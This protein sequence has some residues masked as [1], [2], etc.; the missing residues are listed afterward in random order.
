MIQGI[1]MT[2]QIK[3]QLAQAYQILGH[4]KM[5]DHTYTHLSARAHDQSSLYIYPFGLRFEEVRADALMRVSFDGTILDGHEYQYNK[6]GYLIHGS[7]YEARPDVQAVFHLHTPA[8]VAVSALEEGLMPINQWA[9]HFYGKVAYHAYDSLALVGQQGDQMVHDLG[10]KN[11]ML[12]RHHGALF[13][14]KT[15]QE[16]L[17][18]AYHMEKACQTQCLT[19][20]M[21]RPL[22]SIS[23]EV[24]EKTVKD[25]LSFEKNLGER[26][27][28]AWVRFLQ[29][30]PAT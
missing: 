2:T 14:G 22:V 19:L 16:A 17:F 23:P 18:Y 21:G 9:L 12:L 11:V 6:T 4:L 29:L 24:C 25:L 7:V 1:S 15:L 13:C 26:D 5:D 8:M 28:N 27:W 20:G 10:D 30:D 3:Q